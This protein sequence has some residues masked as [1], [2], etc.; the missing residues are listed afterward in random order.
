MHDSD[1][2]TGGAIARL[3]LIGGFL[4]SAVVVGL[5]LFDE[6]R[7]AGWNTAAT[8]TDFAAVDV[9]DAMSVRHL[10]LNPPAALSAAVVMARSAAAV[11]GADRTRRLDTAD[12]LLDRV[13]SA[14]PAWAPA[15]L[16]R[17][18]VAGVRANGATALTTVLISRS[19]REGPFLRDQAEWRLAYAFSQWNALPPATRIAALEE[20]RWAAG[21]SRDWYQRI[22]LIAAGTNAAAPLKQ[23]LDEPV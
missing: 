5:S 12:L 19:Y 23:R 21:F 10:R 7:A 8:A 1:D 4:I 18:Y 13:A 2:T 9:P 20:A 3:A 14:R 22:R 17:A 15:T 11:S 16:A 6:V